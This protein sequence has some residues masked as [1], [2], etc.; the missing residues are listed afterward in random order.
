MRI[1]FCIFALTA[2]M[3]TLAEQQYS[4][5]KFTDDTAFKCS[6]AEIFV[7]ADKKV[8]QAPDNLKYFT[9]T[10]VNEM[11]DV[12]FETKN[13][14]SIYTYEKF[15]DLKDDWMHLKKN[16]LGMNYV[17]ESES[18]LN[19]IDIF[20]SGKVVIETTDRNDRSAGAIQ[21]AYCPDLRLAIKRE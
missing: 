13:G 17:L 15:I 10:F 18:I 14:S 3:F 4:V 11:D 6:G 7:K 9:L 12:M 1:L 20:A 19:F 8:Y 21:R 5:W 2:S 16:D